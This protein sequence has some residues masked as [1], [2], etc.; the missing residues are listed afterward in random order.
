MLSI[1]TANV[2]P[3]L[4]GELFRFGRVAIERSEIRCRDGDDARELELRIAGNELGFPFRD[5]ADGA[6]VP[7][8]DPESRPVSLLGIGGEAS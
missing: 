2:Q 5:L 3:R 6:S 7:C 1:E 8:A 4:C